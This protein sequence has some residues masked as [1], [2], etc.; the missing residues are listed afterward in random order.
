LRICRLASKRLNE[1]VTIDDD[2]TSSQALVIFTVMSRND[3]ESLV[4][5]SLRED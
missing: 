3:F 1:R 5:Q 2:A 4:G